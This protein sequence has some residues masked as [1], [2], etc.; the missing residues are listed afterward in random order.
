MSDVVIEN[1]AG[2]GSN[3]G[4]RFEHLAAII[5]AVRDPAGVRVCLDACHAFAAGYD[6]RTASG[7]ARTFA[8]LDRLVGFRYLRGVH[9]NDSK[10][11]LGSRLDRHAS[12]GQGKQGW[13]VFR[14][15]MNDPLFEEIP[16]VL[17][18]VDRTIWP[19]EINQLYTL[20]STPEARARTESGHRS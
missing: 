7:C 4:Y 3:F 18:T 11:D 9:V 17:E 19:K 12:L 8:E 5:A 20:Q 6:L 14:F 13:E 2:Q 15:I 1:T 10:C 16:M